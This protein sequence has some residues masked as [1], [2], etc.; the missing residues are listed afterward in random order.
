M[1]TEFI[2]DK[3]KEL[4]CRDTKTGKVTMTIPRY[5]VWKHCERKGK[6]QIVECSNDLQKLITKHGKLKIVKF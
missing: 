4:K 1:I 5:A 6:P 3:G 2:T